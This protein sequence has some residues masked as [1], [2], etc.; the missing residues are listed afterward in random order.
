[1]KVPARSPARSSAAMMMPP[2]ETA[3]IV[4]PVVAPAAAAVVAPP[5]MPVPVAMAAAMPAGAPALVATVPAMMIVPVSTVPLPVPMPVV[6]DVLDSPAGFLQCRHRARPHRIDYRRGGRRHGTAQY[7][8]SDGA[9]EERPH[10]A[11]L[12]TLRH[13]A[14]P[15]DHRAGLPPMPERL[16]KRTEPSMNAPAP[17]PGVAFECWNRTGC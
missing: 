14:A 6:P 10:G 15:F 12:H 4:P 13:V 7:Q 9:Q 5:V 16:Q 11:H 3:P 8:G 1:R 17:T 2:V